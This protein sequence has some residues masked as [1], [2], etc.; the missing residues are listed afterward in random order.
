MTC[1]LYFRLVSASRTCTGAV[2]AM[3]MTPV[4]SPATELK[5]TVSLGTR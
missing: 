3:V 2:K 4:H 1:G 5:N